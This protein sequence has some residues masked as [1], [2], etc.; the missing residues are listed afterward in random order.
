MIISVVGYS[1]PTNYVWYKSRTRQYAFMADSGMHIPTYI[2][3]PTIRNGI[4]TGPGNIGIDTTNNKFYF[5][6]GGAWREAGSTNYAD[7]LRRVGL[8]VQMR[9]GGVWTDQYTDSVGGGGSSDSAWTLINVGR[10]PIIGDRY[11]YSW[12][13]NP[14]TLTASLGGG[15]TVTTDG[16]GTSI[17][18]GGW[19]LSNVL[20]VP[21]EKFA[22]HNW[23]ITSTIVVGS[24]TSTSYGLRFACMPLSAGLG[25]YVEYLLSDTAGYIVYTST[26]GLSITG[27][28]N[29]KAISKFRW[30]SGDTL[31]FSIRRD[32]RDLFVLMN[33]R[34]SN[35]QSK[36]YVN[37][38]SG[39]PLGT[40]PY[41]LSINTLGGSWKFIDSLKVK[42]YDVYRPKWATLGT[43]ITYGADAYTQGVRWTNQ[44]FDGDN[45]GWVDLSANSLASVDG[46][47]MVSDIV[48][49]IKP[50]YAIIDY[51]INDLQG[52]VPLDSFSK[53]M[54][55]MIDPMIA[56]G[57][58]PVLCTG[59][60]IALN[61]T[62]YNDTVWA[63]A[64][65]YGLMV[66][67]QFTNLKADATTNID[68][69][70]AGTDGIH[71]SQ[72]GHNQIAEAARATL[73]S[74]ITTGSPI[75]MQLVPFSFNRKYNLGLN[76][77][78]ELVKTLA[79][80]DT[81]YIRNA[82]YPLAARTA[83]PGNI[84]IKGNAWIGGDDFRVFGL[85]TYTSP[86][87]S[88]NIDKD[89]YAKSPL[90]KS[91]GVNFGNT[92]ITLGGE[93]FN[94]F[95]YD[96]RS[97]QRPWK[98]N[99]NYPAS[100]GSLGLILNTTNDDNGG[101]LPA[102]YKF[103]SVRN[104]GTEK[105]HINR[106]GGFRT[107][108]TS[109]YTYNIN[110]L[111]TDN[112]WVSKK[113]VD[114]VAVP[115]G[116]TVYVDS[117]YINGTNDSLI[118]RKNGN[119]YAYLIPS[120]G[121]GGWGTTGTVATLTGSSTLAQGG[122]V[123]NISGGLV[124]M[125]TSS[126]SSYLAGQKGLVVYDG[127]PAISITTGSKFF[128]HYIDANYLRLYEQN[129]GA[130][131]SWKDGR[132]GIGS[133]APVSTLDVSGSVGSAITTITG[134]TTLGESHSTVIVTSGTP[135]ITLPAASGVSRRKYRIVNQTSSA[136]TVSTYK[137]FAGADA[138]TIAA[139]SA[140]EFQSNGTSWYRIL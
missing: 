56:A 23:E 79:T 80:D 48:N 128:M 116:G 64:S 124:G 138:T 26:D 115:G 2:S 114:S 75:N 29:N 6:S 121:G 40:S 34:T 136:V 127:T 82:I 77:K 91:N 58:T 78:G 51:V 55:R 85:G 92:F 112:D 119:R 123:F 106:A 93:S 22:T 1:Q 72:Y 107:D 70:F 140:I 63:L 67:D 131:V 126:P 37:T 113:Y 71:P 99:F 11:T 74:L 20:S 25:I 89:G 41:S 36:L 42:Y 35:T 122:N 54:Q 38:V 21:N 101:V 129:V 5:Y 43:S 84:N 17:S 45:G 76:Y 49:N 52:S 12:G 53:R 15:A 135:T 88:V 60:P 100:A 120:G 13:N 24:K 83:T 137:D 108:T 7:S 90:F 19:N 110:S 94:F 132:T 68:T 69:K 87:F 62:P 30:S 47:L 44:L 14:I 8:A 18:G 118:V 104:N 73:G 133:T 33:N 39:T 102:A 46:A 134:N 61:S 139:N 32:G 111:L 10:K 57:V 109:G 103:L 105:A 95:M 50:T 81:T 16:T 4:W 27:D 28:N 125:G 3:T 65:R 97:Y 59:V 130:I 98:I 86:S 66:I 9:K 96:I 117:V 31:D